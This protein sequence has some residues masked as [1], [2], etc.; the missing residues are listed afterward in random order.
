MFLARTHSAQLCSGN[1][2]WVALFSSETETENKTPWIWPRVASR[3]DGEVLHR[4]GHLIFS[5]LKHLPLQRAKSSYA[6]VFASPAVSPGSLGSCSTASPDTELPQV[7]PTPASGADAQPLLLPI[8]PSLH[9]AVTPFSVSLLQLRLRR[10]VLG[11]QRQVLQLSVRFTQVQTLELS[12]GP[13]A[14]EHLVPGHAGK[15]APR[16][17]LCHSSRPLLRLRSPETDLF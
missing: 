16:H 13:A 5:S 11:H 4:A 3:C 17:Q 6:S 10:Q 1:R 14:G 8:V 2:P 7:L 12:A 15:R 9:I